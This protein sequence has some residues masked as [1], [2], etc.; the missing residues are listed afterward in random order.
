[1][2]FRIHQQKIEITAIPITYAVVENRK[3]P[4]DLYCYGTTNEIYIPVMPDLT[5]CCSIM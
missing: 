2:D 4:F 5:S 3:K 1:M